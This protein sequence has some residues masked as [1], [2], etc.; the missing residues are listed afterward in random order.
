M[1]ASWKVS[2]LLRKVK[3]DNVPQKASKNKFDVFGLTDGY[4]FA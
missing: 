4:E 2:F 1:C 3:T